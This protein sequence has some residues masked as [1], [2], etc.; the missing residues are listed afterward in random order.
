MKLIESAL[1][2]VLLLEPQVFA[3]DRG[4]FYESYNQARFAALGLSVR[5]VQ[6]N[7]SRSRRGVLR[8]LHYQWPNPQGKLVQVVE[9]EVFDVAV[10]LRRG[11]PHFGRSFGA[12]LSAQNKRSMYIPEGFA[13]GFATLSEHATFAYQCTALYDREGDRSLR[14]N[15]PQLGIEWPLSEPLLSPKD[16]AAPLLA[17]LQP[18]QLPDAGQ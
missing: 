14:W 10:D 17:D 9:G 1:D 13:H 7:L 15:D 11:S 2:G 8:G 18:E 16:A 4:W 3:D 5:F 12:L 6:S